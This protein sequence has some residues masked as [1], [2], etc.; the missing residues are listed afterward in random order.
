MDKYISMD[1]KNHKKYNKKILL[2]KCKN[3]NFSR[4]EMKKIIDNYK[5]YLI[6]NE[7]ISLIFDTTTLEIDLLSVPSA[8]KMVWSGA[9]MLSELNE[10]A[11]KNVICS[12]II[13]KNKFFRDTFNTIIKVNKVIV[14]YKIVENDSDAFSFVFSKIKENQKI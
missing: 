13:I 11:K 12:C 14:P 3:F 6:E 9:S 5:K 1:L 8:T 7:D 10:I 2:V 4:E